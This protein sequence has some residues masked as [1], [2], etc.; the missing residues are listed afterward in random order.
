MRLLIFVSLFFFYYLLV[1]FSCGSK[2]SSKSNVLSIAEPSFLRQI[3]V[4]LLYDFCGEHRCYPVHHIDIFDDY[5]GSSSPS[6]RE[7]G[8]SESPNHTKVELQ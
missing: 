8:G 4:F 2:T 3:I 6:Y 7:V 5:R 1:F